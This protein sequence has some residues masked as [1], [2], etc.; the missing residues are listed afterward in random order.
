[1]NKAELPQFLLAVITLPGLFTQA[2][3]AD[4]D[5]SGTLQSPLVHVALPDTKGCPE[6]VKNGGTDPDASAP[7]AGPVLR[8]GG[9]VLMPHLTSK[10]EPDYTEQAFDARLQGEVVLRLV[11]DPSGCP[12]SIAVVAPLGLGL[13]EKAA[14][15]I[16]T[17]RWFPATKDGEPVAV[18]AIIKV[19]FRLL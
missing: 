11:I 14:Q 9:A 4:S 12:R 5:V 15:A 2:V 18:R 1:M 16:A 3:F 17:W 13:D 19:S 6:L 10:V 7:F 8:N